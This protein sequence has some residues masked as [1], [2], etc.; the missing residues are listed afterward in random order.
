MSDN[1]NIFS[2]MNRSP[3]FRIM[4]IAI[5]LLQLVEFVRNP[6]LFWL[7]LPAGSVKQL[8]RALSGPIPLRAMKKPGLPRE[9]HAHS[10][11]RYCEA[12]A[13]SSQ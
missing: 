13:L 12:C 5:V 10:H 8:E 2:T 1:T 6:D 7:P 11:A 4:R 9:N 3:L